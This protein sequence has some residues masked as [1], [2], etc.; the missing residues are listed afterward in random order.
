MK[1]RFTATFDQ[2]G[3]GV[4]ACNSLLIL[5]NT[6]FDIS[7]QMINTHMSRQEIAKSEG[8]YKALQ[9]SNHDVKSK[10]SIAQLMPPLWAYAF[11]KD[12]F[13]VGWFFWESDRIC[14]EWIKIINDGLCNEVWVPCISNYN[15]LVNSGIKKPIFVVPQYTKFNFIDEEQANTI[16]PIPNKNTYRFYSIF[17][18]SQ[19]KNPESLFKAYFNEFSGQEDVMLVVKTYGP[20]PFADRRR[21]KEAILDFKE[22]SNSTAPVYLFGELLT[23]EQINAIHAQCHCYVYSGRAEGW[24]IP[25]LESIA[26]KKQ[27]ITTKTGGIAD[28]ITDKSAYIIPH[29]QIAINTEGHIWGTYYK[30]NPSQHWGDVDVIDV[31]NS[32][33]KAYEEKNNYFYRI[34]HYD[35]ILNICN[36]DHVTKIIKERLSKIL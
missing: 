17:Q 29:K 14:D 2:S 16:L 4:A 35:K 13:N 30:S 34:N 3:Y 31:Q 27:I 33:R 11:K 21:I 26:Y 19:R 10:V 23:N 15:A 36:E 28:W 12:T 18:W 1:I 24:N 6:G 8:Y 20:S 7:T 5:L 32:M 25:L 9:Y 22:K